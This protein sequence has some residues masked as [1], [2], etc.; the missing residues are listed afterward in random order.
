MKCALCGC[1]FDES[2]SD[3]ACKGCPMTRGCGLI[4]CPNCGF[5]TTPEPR[6]VRYL[7]SRIRERS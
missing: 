5:E 4:R 7:K 3:H 1:E 2:R 6:W